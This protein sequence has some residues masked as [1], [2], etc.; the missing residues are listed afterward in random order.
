ML[1]RA[2]F[3]AQPSSRTAV[4]V[5]DG[6]L[7][8]VAVAEAVYA[9]RLAAALLARWDSM[10]VVA[11]SPMTAAESSEMMHERRRTR[12]LHPH[13]VREARALGGAAAAAAGCAWAL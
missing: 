9:A 11:A 8:P 3:A 13:I 12:R 10:P 4:E 5:A 6:A 1:T 2:G 7:V